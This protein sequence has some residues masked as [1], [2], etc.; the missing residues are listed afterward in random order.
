MRR[1][2][3]TALALAALTLCSAPC[4]AAEA[5][6][7]DPERITVSGMSAG[8]NMAHQLHVA[9]ADLFSGVAVLAG[10]PFGCAQ[11]SLATALAR[12]V[13]TVGD[14]IPVAELEAGTRA[15][16][17]AGRVADPALLA[18]DRVWLFRGTQDKAVAEGV[19]DALAELYAA[20]VPAEQVL[21]VEDVEVPHLFPTDRGGWPC[22]SLQTPFVGDC[23]YD[24][25]GALL[26][27]LY[28]ELED[29][30]GEGTGPLQEVPL[31]GAEA[32]GLAATAWL[33]VPESCTKGE[34]ACALHL[35]LHGCAQSVSMVG[36]AFMER[37]GYLPWAEA[38]GIV[39]AFPQAVSGV[40][41]PLGCFDWWGY[42][43]ADYA[44]RDGPQ[45]RVIADWV[46]SLAAP[47]D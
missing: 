42:S 15:A 46:R 34:E 5:P 28:G 6:R 18:D 2:I 41:N 47:A 16:A 32:A 21:Y 24:A 45:M 23:G 17:D 11:G 1:P 43:G 20:F 31:P 22:D 36:N 38:N 19:S 30:E 8:G 12:C 44:W 35:V 26:R 14:G 39:L 27:H 7:I 40:T 3:P 29:F 13:T 10:G 4:M 37:S 9:Y 33:Y 25:A